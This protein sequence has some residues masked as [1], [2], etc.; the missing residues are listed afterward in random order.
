[1]TSEQVSNIEAKAFNE[2]EKNRSA[3]VNKFKKSINKEGNP[4]FKCFSKKYEYYSSDMEI[5]GKQI[6]KNFPDFGFDYFV[7]NNI[8]SLKEKV[9]EKKNFNW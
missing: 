8:K 5:L 2:A 1:M 9:K 6:M 3:Q 4:V 7:V